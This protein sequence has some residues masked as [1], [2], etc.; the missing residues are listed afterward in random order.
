LTVVAPHFLIGDQVHHVSGG[1][2]MTVTHIDG[3]WVTVAWFDRRYR[4][5]VFKATML[6]VA[7][8][9]A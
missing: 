1:V 8:V 3:E 4:T 2:T 6:K 9:A 5:A 7:R